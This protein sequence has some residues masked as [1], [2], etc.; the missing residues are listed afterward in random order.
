M[1]DDWYGASIITD[2]PAP[3]SKVIGYGVWATSA[4]FAPYL[5][6]DLGKLWPTAEAAYAWLHRMLPVPGGVWSYQVVKLE[7]VE[8]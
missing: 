5:C 6:K 8:P 1:I 7:E 3:A 4:E 2:E